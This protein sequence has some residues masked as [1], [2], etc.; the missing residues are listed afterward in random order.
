MSN[1]LTVVLEFTGDGGDVDSNSLLQW[2]RNEPKLSSVARARPA[3]QR[4][5][6]LRLPAPEITVFL[7]R[8]Q[9]GILVSSI[10]SFLL[11]RRSDTVIKITL[12]KGI[13]FDIRSIGADKEELAQA[14][15]EAV[16]GDSA[17]NGN[18]SRFGDKTDI[19]ARAH[20]A[21]AMTFH[22]RSTPPATPN[23][24]RHSTL[25]VTIYLADESSHYQVE[26][27][28]EA[29]LTIAGL[30]V[31]DREDPVL[32]SWFRRMVAGLKEAIRTPLAREAAMTAAHAAD[33]RLVLAQDAAVT[34]MLLQ[35]VGPVIASL[36]STKDAVIRAGA[37]L[38]VKV[39]WVVTVTQLTAAQ[40]LTLDHHPE[41]ARSPQEIIEALNISSLQ[42]GGAP[43]T[44]P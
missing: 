18:S 40:Q 32:G 1:S 19:G 23:S 35:N 29:L 11:T 5:D 25:P 13:S 43:H 2:L 28:V 4:P 26:T 33:T 6:E 21:E 44:R 41:L 15:M 16:G 42:I 36:Q 38:I 20:L 7:V 3:N 14:L 9:V 22:R 10:H 24:A 17:S 31:V 12:S 27:A 34:A 30:R 37:L 8:E 39:E